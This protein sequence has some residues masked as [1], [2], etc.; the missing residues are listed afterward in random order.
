MRPRPLKQDS[1]VIRA[2]GFADL[3][4]TAGEV[5]RQAKDAPTVFD[6]AKTSLKLQSDTLDQLTPEER[7]ELFE[8]NNQR[9][10]KVKRLQDDLMIETDDVRA[11]QLRTELNDLV[12]EK[13]Y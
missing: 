3:S 1:A 5:F 12:E 8:Q 4:V 2:T 11:D 13:D 10:E 9:I 7:V 6:L